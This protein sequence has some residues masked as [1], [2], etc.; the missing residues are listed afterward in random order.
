MS[1][2]EIQLYLHVILFVVLNHADEITQGNVAESTQ[3]ILPTN[4][5]SNFG[6]SFAI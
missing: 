2:G 3:T 1:F 4:L 6:T 5:E